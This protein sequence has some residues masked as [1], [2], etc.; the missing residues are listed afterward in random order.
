VRLVGVGAGLHWVRG[1]GPSQCHVGF[2]GGH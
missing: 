1:D 2:A